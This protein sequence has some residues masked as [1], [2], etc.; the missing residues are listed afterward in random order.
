L[1]LSILEAVPTW[2]LVVSLLAL[3]LL[4]GFVIGAV[5]YLYHRRGDRRVGTR[6]YRF[7]NA[8]RFW[9]WMFCGVALALL[10]GGCMERAVI[11]PPTVP[12]RLAQKLYGVHVWVK[13][14]DGKEVKARADLF[15]G[16]IIVTDPRDFPTEARAKFM[17]LRGDE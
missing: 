6:D 13:S 11:V 9:P 2:A 3:A 4:G 17:N 10:L 8:H 16:M 12:V 14:L 5:V 15:P 7:P 1:T